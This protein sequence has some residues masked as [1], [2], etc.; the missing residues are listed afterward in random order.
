MSQVAIVEA[1]KDLPDPRRT[2]GQ[3]HANSDLFGAVYPRHCLRQ[4]RASCHRGLSTTVGY[5]MQL[6]NCFKGYWQRSP[7]S[8]EFSVN[9]MIQVCRN[10]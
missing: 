7:H 5:P 2:T 6:K 3:R 10:K 9:N 4:S 1:F 8:T